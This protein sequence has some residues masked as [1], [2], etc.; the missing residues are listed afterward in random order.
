MLAVI[1]EACTAGLMEEWSFV[2]QYCWWHLAYRCR[3]AV[4]RKL[5]GCEY[6][7][8]FWVAAGLAWINFSPV[9]SWE[10][11]LSLLLVWRLS[12]YLHICYTYCI[13]KMMFTGAAVVG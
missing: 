1:C 9:W 10:F 8:S 4:V 13:R 5:A 12:H 11:W 3:F 7:T 2:N 6:C